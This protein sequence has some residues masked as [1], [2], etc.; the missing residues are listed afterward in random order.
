[1][2]DAAVWSAPG[3]LQALRYVQWLHRGP[4][5]ALA[6]SKCSHSQ[7]PTG[8]RVGGASAC[9]PP[10]L[11]PSQRAWVSRVA[12]NTTRPQTSRIQ[13]EGQVFPQ[14]WGF[15]FCFSFLLRENSTANFIFSSLQAMRPLIQGPLVAPDLYQAWPGTEASFFLCDPSLIPAPVPSVPSLQVRPPLGEGED[16][17]VERRD[18]S[19]TP[20]PWPPPCPCPELASRPAITGRP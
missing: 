10:L 15:V 4:S 11:T 1:M 14:G 12:A 16:S 5:S 17:P 20:G 18:W 2:S 3:P 6:L 7:K 19:W 9:P 13:T 8:P